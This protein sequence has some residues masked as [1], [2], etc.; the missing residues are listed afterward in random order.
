MPSSMISQDTRRAL[1]LNVVE[2]AFAVASD[3]L[4]GPYL[5]LFAMALNATPSQIVLLS[6]FP[7]LLG[8]ILQIPFGMLAETV[9]DKRILCIIGGFLARASWIIIAFLPF[10]FPPEQRIAVLIVLAS[11]RI[12]AANLGGPAWTVLKAGIVP[13]SIRGKYYANRNVVLNFCA[14]LVTFAA[15]FLLS[16][17]FPIN[18]YILFVVAAA[19]GIA[20]TYVF[21]QIPFPPPEEKEKRGGQTTK[22]YLAVFFRSAQEN[23]NF[24]NYV[25]SAVVWNFGVSFLGTLTAVYFVQ[26][27][28]GHEGAWA[29]V[30]ASS[31]LAQTICQ[32]Y[33]GPLADKFGPKNVM[34]VSGI[35][36][37][38][39]P[40]MWF[41][42]PVSWLG[43]VINF[44]SGFMLGGYH[45]AAF[46]LLLELT[47]DDN[48]S[49]YIGAYNT[50]M[51]LAT[52]VGPV[53]GGFTAELLGL[54]SIF[55]FSF[56]VRV[57]GLFLFN[58]GVSD[59][60]YRRPTRDDLIPLRRPSKML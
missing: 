43:L 18:Y 48:R 59:S 2:G 19:L 45:L 52:A 35:A 41:L 23:R 36:V 30:T 44:V 40:V 12:V 39:V 3:N 54:R 4:A 47:P 53:L 25:Y 28:G 11:L 46:N 26:D 7:N 57:V 49:M 31:L 22:E 14:L 10:L 1:K 37:C 15:G 38:F 20:S 16:L 17:R 33:W 32:R 34:A 8:N 51:G 50:F 6:A 13:K 27:M 60:G 56:G 5:T 55:L 58:R 42:A 24:V 29:L 21:R 9:R